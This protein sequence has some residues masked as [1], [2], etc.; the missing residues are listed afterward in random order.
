MNL[1]VT[2]ITLF[3]LI[4]S[5]LGIYCPPECSSCTSDFVCDSCYALDSTFLYEGK[6]MPC[7]SDCTS[8]TNITIF[9]SC[10]SN[11]ELL[12]NNMCIN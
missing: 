4:H 9:T 6:C 10:S 2:L 7:P 1:Q 8:C 5:S 3:I 12:N 11:A